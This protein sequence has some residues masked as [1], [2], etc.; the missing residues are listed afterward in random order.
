METRIKTTM[1]GAIDAIKQEFEKEIDSDP[2]FKERFL[3]LRK[4]IL[5]L[6]NNQIRL[7]K[8]EQ[9]NG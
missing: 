6:G 9:E 7:N 8:R 4:N 2:V 5:D 1:I 3:R